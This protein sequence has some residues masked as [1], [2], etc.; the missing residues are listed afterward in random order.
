MYI[1]HNVVAMFYQIKFAFFLCV[2]VVCSLIYSMEKEKLSVPKYF[3]EE[4]VENKYFLFRL[5]LPFIFE[6]S[7]SLQKLTG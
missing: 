2:C 7:A 5:L 1:L 4:L 6:F 3:K